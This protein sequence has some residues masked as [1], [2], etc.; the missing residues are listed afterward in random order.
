MRLLRRHALASGPDV[1]IDDG[2][3]DEGIQDDD[4]FA[5]FV[6]VSAVEVALTE[7][8]PGIET[9]GNLEAEAVEPLG[10]DA[11]RRVVTRQN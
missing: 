11:G 9:L 2:I 10:I 4:P 1:T 5:G 7:A 8:E 6:E 3:E